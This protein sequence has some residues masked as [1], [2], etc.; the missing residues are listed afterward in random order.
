VL[1]YEEQMWEL[2]DLTKGQMSDFFEAYYG[3]VKEVVPAE[4]VK[5]QE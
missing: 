1:K 2:F 5:K 3:S 4:K